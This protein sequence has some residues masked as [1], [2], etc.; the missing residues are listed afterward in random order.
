MVPISC[1]L[2]QLSFWYWV[3]KDHPPATRNMHRWRQSDIS[4]NLS[5]KI[6]SQMVLRLESRRSLESSTIVPSAVEARSP[7]PNSSGD[8]SFLIPKNL[9]LRLGLPSTLI[10]HQNGAFRKRSSNQRNLKTP[11]IFVFVW[12]KH[13]EN[14]HSKN[15]FKFRKQSFSRSNSLKSR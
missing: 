4:L 7:F 14:T 3:P 10:R 6:H 12:R 5:Q 2:V 13:F 15:T 9:Y 1:Y 8:L 11:P